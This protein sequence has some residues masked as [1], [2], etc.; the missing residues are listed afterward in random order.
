MGFNELLESI[1]CILLVVEASS[2]QKVVKMLEEVV[3]ICQEVRWIRLEVW[4]IQ[5]MRQ[6]FTAQFVQVLKCWLFDI[7][8]S[9]VTEKNRAHSIDPAASTASFRCISSICWGYFSD[10]M[11]SPG[12]RKLQWLR[13]SADHQTVAVTF[14]GASLALGST[15]ELLLGSTTELVVAGHWIKSTLHLTSQ[16]S[17]EMVH[18]CCKNKR[19]Q[20]MKIM[21]FFFLFSSW[22]TH[23]SSFFTFPICFKCQ[24][25]IE[26]LTLSSWATSC[27][28]GLATMMVLSWSLLTPGGKALC[29]SFSRLLSPLQNFLQHHC[30][31]C[32]L[33]V[34]GPN[35]L[36]MLR[37]VSAALQPILNSR[38]LLE[39]AFCLTSF[40]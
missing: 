10:V 16:S 36:L 26:W 14:F 6:N 37:V 30:I 21:I 22:G 23:L 7:R 9:V 4:W 40:P 12:F 13:T 20:H 24:M 31:V 17:Q 11:V 25:P 35:A 32:S 2:L 33:A 38:K 8:S 5:Q 27:A 18:C 29:F 3:V 1:F 15:L 34:P 39:F 19:R 28:R